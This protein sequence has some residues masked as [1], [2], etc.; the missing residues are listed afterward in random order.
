MLD[1]DEQKKPPT[2]NERKVGEALIEILDNWEVI[3]ENMV[4]GAKYHKNNLLKTIRD[5]TNLHTKDVRVA[6]R[7]YKKLYWLVKSD[8]IDDGY[9]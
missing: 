5:Y 7:K 2:E 1:D 3:F 6:L 8:K 9:M 4:G